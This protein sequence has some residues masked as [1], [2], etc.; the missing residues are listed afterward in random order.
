MPAG[1]DGRRTDRAPNRGVAYTVRF[2]G[3]RWA[4]LIFV[5][6]V[7][8]LVFPAPSG[9]TIPVFAVGEVSD[10]DVIAPV[11]FTIR[12][13]TEVLARERDSLASTVHPIYRYNAAAIDSTLRRLDGFFTAWEAQPSD[14]GER[15]AYAAVDLSLRERE[16][17]ASPIR[18]SEIRAVLEDAL[19][20]ELRRGVV[21]DTVLEREAHESVTVI[22]GDATT[23]VPRDSLTNLSDLLGVAREALSHV[24]DDRGPHIARKLAGV[25]ARATLAPDPGETALRREE[26]GR[27]VDSTEAVI[28]AGERIVGAGEV[29]TAA[30]RG[31]LLQLR[32]AA[33]RLSATQPPG[34]RLLAPFLYNVIVLSI[35]WLLL[36]FYRAPLY[37]HLREVAFFTALFAVVI[38]VSGYVAGLF[39]ARPELLPIPFAAILVAMLYNG[40]LAVLAAVTLA[41]LLGGQWGLRENNT[42]FFGLV[43]GVAAAFGVRAV[44]RR[45][46]LFRTIGIVVGAYGL[47]AVTL[48]LT[49]GWAPRAVVTST[50]AGGLTALVSAA[51]ALVLLPLAERATSVTTDLTLLELSDPG[52]Q[53]LRRL[54]L[55]APGTYAHSLMMANL[56]DVACTAIG[57]NGLLA[58]VGCFYHDIGKLKRPHYFVENQKPGHNPHDGLDPSESARIIRAHVED[59]LML[60]KEARLPTAVRAFITEH[61]GTGEIAYFLDQARNG[62]DLAHDDDAQFCYPGPKPQSAETAVAMLADAAEAAIRVLEDPNP[63]VVRRALDHLVRHKLVSGQLDEAPLTMQQ[64]E[65][66]KEEFGAALAGIHHQRLEYPP[67]R[68]GISSTFDDVI[69]E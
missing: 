8:T 36:L 42:L 20:G 59:G 25:A 12:K 5:A 34:R 28:R 2:H 41:A 3:L 53:L 14:A 69:D 22:R 21:A 57:A 27:S 66:I 30:T 61:H 43:G 40:R 54:A 64:L 4:L 45:D 67:E 33:S 19:R 49:Y 24:D 51:L 38:V 32:A 17:L 56:S 39:P 11:G 16:Y 26:R 68:G 50:L 1:L 15:D 52:R 58:R 48:G 63:D 65:R 55:E 31:R 10:R 62:D 60:A 18:R 35:F 29:V 6:V 9:P 44:R 23:V 37:S 7:T 13:T 47:A 46:Q